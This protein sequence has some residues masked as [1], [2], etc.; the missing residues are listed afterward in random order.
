[1]QRQSNV[2]CEPS[3]IIGRLRTNAATPTPIVTLRSGL[4]QY[5]S[6]SS[7]GAPY[8]YPDPG[9]MF[10]GFSSS[11]ADDN[12]TP[13]QIHGAPGVVGLAGGAR[14]DA[15]LVLNGTSQYGDLADTTLLR[16]STDITFA[17]L[18]QVTS[19]VGVRMIVAKSKPSTNQH[20]YSLAYDA[21]SNRFVWS[22]TDGTARRLAYGPLNPQ[23]GLWYLLVADYD[24]TLRVASLTVNSTPTSVRTSGVTSDTAGAVFRIG[25]DADGSFFKG[26]IEMVARWNRLLNEAEKASLF[27]TWLYTLINGSPVFKAASDSP[28]TGYPLPSAIPAVPD[29]SVSFSSPFLVLDWVNNA[30]NAMAIEVWREISDA[31]QPLLPG[32]VE[33]YRLVYTANSYLEAGWTDPVSYSSSNTYAYK[34]RALNLAGASAFSAETQF[35]GSAFLTETGDNLQTED[36][37]QNIL[38]EDQ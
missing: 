25:A 38:L 17:A 29:L 1:M 14:W 11:L 12:L 28:P 3:P 23:V 37:S 10:D 22:V 6:V 20:E 13:V 26:G 33:P 36:G 16:F 9:D 5:W 19:K 24:K 18:V 4:A 35:D 2:L 30:P 8:V 31:S 32:A 27:T 21:V 7:G 34:I 15:A